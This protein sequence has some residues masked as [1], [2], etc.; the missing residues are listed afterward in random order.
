MEHQF[1]YLVCFSYDETTTPKKVFLQKHEAITWGR[2]QATKLLKTDYNYTVS[3]YK[4]EIARRSV[5]E[6]VKDLKPY[7]N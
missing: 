7:E 2:R 6:F 1:F 5:L 3:L 4:Q